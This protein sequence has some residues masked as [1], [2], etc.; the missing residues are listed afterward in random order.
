MKISSIFV[1]FSEN[2]NFKEIRV[3]LLDEF[4]L[5]MRAELDNYEI[6]SITSEV[7][8]SATQFFK[9]SYKI[10]HPPGLEASWDALPSFASSSQSAKIGLSK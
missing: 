8:P 2:V 3:S 4:N 9:R 5:Q 10:S 7:T 6:K 1:A